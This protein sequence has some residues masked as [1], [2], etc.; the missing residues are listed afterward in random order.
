[1]LIWMLLG[2][3]AGINLIPIFVVNN[4]DWSAHLGGFITG[5][6]FGSY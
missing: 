2:L 6:L 4:V 1:M 5:G 3:I